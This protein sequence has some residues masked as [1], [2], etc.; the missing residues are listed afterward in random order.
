MYEGQYHNFGNILPQFTDQ[1]PTDINDEIGSVN[2]SA[3]NSV[4][5][6]SSEKDY[7]IPEEFKDYPVD[8]DETIDTPLTIRKKTHTQDRKN[9]M[10]GIA[11]R[12]GTTKANR[13]HKDH[14][15]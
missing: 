3:E 11:L 1:L 12:K 5:R 9:F 7:A 14:R 2:Y 15:A 4:I 8:I 13:R 6:F 10:L